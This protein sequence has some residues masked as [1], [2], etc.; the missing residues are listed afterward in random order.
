MPSNALSLDVFD[1][2]QK[3]VDCVTEAV[4]LTRESLQS[5]GPRKKQCSNQVRDLERKGDRILRDIMTQLERKVEVSLLNRED[6]YRI[7]S[8]LD[9]VLDSLAELVDCINSF[10]LVDFPPLACRLMD[11]AEACSS[12]LN[13]IIDD[14]GKRLRPSDEVARI[15]RLHDEAYEIYNMALEELF[16]SERNAIRLVK[17]KDTYAIIKKVLDSFEQ[18]A[19]AIEDAVLKHKR[20]F[21]AR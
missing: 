15:Y 13:K 14:T 2:V 5:S 9:D 18:A 12:A 11:T 8:H 20:V 16:Y 17:L 19:Q 4:Q 3:Q 10:R 1:M 21:T 7:V 6:V